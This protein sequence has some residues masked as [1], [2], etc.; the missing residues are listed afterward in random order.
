MRTP[1]LLANKL[2]EA[3][4]FLDRMQ[5]TGRDGQAL[6]F[7]FSAFSAA[8]RSITFVIQ[9]VGRSRQIADFEE[10]YENV[11]AK[12]KANPLARYFRDIRTAIQKT[13]FSPINRGA[14]VKTEDGTE[15][16]VHFF[17]YFPSDPPEDM[18][19]IDVISACK[20]YISILINITIDFY[21]QFRD[22]L[23]METAI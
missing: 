23:K 15:Q 14:V 1:N 2:K 8:A 13:G 19:Q 9:S 5:E 3:D 7:Y 12:L 17:S 4:F 11:Q 10:W 16:L 6:R 18:P 20:V 22:E 21:E